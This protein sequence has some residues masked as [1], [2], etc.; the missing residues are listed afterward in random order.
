MLEKG[1]F[2][3]HSEQVMSEDNLQ[4]WVLSFHHVGFRDQTQ[5]IS[6]FIQRSHLIG[7]KILFFLH[8]SPFLRPAATQINEGSK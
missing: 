4:E 1:V 3:W 8:L 5:L 2:T 6:T 7:S